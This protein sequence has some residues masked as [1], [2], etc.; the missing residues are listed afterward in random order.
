MKL[1]KKII[2]IFLATTLA[3]SS[4]TVPTSASSS[5]SDNPH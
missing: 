1:N 4:M 2:A 3:V 5:S